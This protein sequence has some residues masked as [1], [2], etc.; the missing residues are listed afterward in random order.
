MR[1]TDGE[2]DPLVPPSR[3]LPDGEMGRRIDVRWDLACG[4]DDRDLVVLLPEDTRFT[5]GELRPTISEIRSRTAK[6]L[7]R[8][9][10]NAGNWVGI[11]PHFHYERALSEFIAAY[12][13]HLEDG[14]VPHPDEKVRE[15]VFK[16]RTRLDVL[17]LYRDER[18]VI[19]ECKQGQPTLTAIAQLRHYMNLLS[20]ETDR[21]DARGM[22]VHGGARKLRI[23]VA[24][25]ARSFPPV[26]IVQYRLQVDFAL[27]RAD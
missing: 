22:L 9:M 15:R 27:S 11:S 10:N 19:A 7:Q 17:L 8:A 3:H 24:R 12:P 2:W 5:S 25:V 1:V 4:P 14:L 20:E 23:E 18:P 16:D 21:N 26:E 6:E 13:H